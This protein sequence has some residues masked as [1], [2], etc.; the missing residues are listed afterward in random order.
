M[1]F[2]NSISSVAYA[3]IFSFIPK[4]SKNA[5]TFFVGLAFSRKD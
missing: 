2:L 5:D 3:K 1:N 4:N